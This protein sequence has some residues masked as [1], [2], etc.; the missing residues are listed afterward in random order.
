[1]IWSPNRPYFGRSCA[2]HRLS[3]FIGFAPAALTFLN[4]QAVSS[5]TLPT[6]SGK[7]GSRIPETEEAASQIRARWRPPSE[8]LNKPHVPHPARAD[9]QP[10]SLSRQG[11]LSG[12]AATRRAARRRDASGRPPLR[13]RKRPQRLRS[14]SASV[15]AEILFPDADARRAVGGIAQPF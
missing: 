3:V 4:R 7:C 15:D 12:A 9:R 8:S 11:P 13:H 6:T 10:L 2:R 5:P 14:L 1:M